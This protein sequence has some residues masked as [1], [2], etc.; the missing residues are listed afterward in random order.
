MLPSRL[1]LAMSLSLILLV[2]LAGCGPASDNPPNLG[3]RASM[4][5]SSLSTQG[6]SPHHDAFTPIATPLPL[7]SVN[8]TGSV[9]GGETVPG[10]N[11]PRAIPVLASEAGHP[12]DGLIVP[13]WIVQKVN[14]PNVRVRLGA[15]DTWAQS[16]PPG[17]IDR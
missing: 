16:A 7:A 3:P 10:G 5:G 6:L 4:D 13:E 17:V 2:G 8:G 9:S 14:A 15:L 1:C 11:S 12:V